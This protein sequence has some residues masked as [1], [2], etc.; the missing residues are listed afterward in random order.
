MSL[1]TLDIGANDFLRDLNP[2]CTVNVTQF[3]TDLQT[4]D[5]NL[6]TLIL[7]Q[8]YAALMVHG[9]ITGD[10]MLLNYY[11]PFQNVCHGAI[12]PFIRSINQ[13]LA[14]DVEGFGTLVN[15]FGPFGGNT[16]PPNPKVCDFTWMCSVPLAL[17][18]DIHPTTKGYQ[19]MANAI[20]DLYRQRVAE[21]SSNDVERAYND[22]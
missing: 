1:I 22:I 3:T 15:I 5:V 21:A 8:L 4:L 18:Q 19:V 11:D 9:R 12:T 17:P 2:D 20:E 6:K 14:S 7:P 10:L 13:H 16:T